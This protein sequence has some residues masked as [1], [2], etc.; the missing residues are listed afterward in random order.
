MTWPVQKRLGDEVCS[1]QHANDDTAG[2]WCKRSK[3]ESFRDESFFDLFEAAA[4][5]MAESTRATGRA[6]R[7][8]RR[9]GSPGGPPRKPPRATPPAQARPKAAAGL[10]GGG[11]ELEDEGDRVYL[12]V[13]AEL[14]TFTGEHPA[15]YVLVLKD[16]IEK[17]EK[18]LDSLDH[19]THTVESIVLKCG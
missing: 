16:I 6:A 19:V 1:W 17:L 11:D 4:D 13:R 10:S 12:R 14:Y 9:P 2:D 5:N 8:L 3:G 7:R 15:R 18:A